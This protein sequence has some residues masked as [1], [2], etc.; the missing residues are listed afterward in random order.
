MKT[1]K[2]ISTATL[3]LIMIL[4]AV[5]AIPASAVVS[6]DRD[7]DFFTDY[8]PDGSI[9]AQG[10]SEVTTYG[11]EGSAFTQFTHVAGN[12]HVT[13][14]TVYVG[15]KFWHYPADTSQANYRTTTKNNTQ[16]GGSG[17]TASVSL[18]GG[19]ISSVIF[20]VESTH[21]LQYTCY[22]QTYPVQTVW[23]CAGEPAMK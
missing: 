12:N 21:T 7:S 6:Y 11:R 5:L 17:T 3:V 9:S 15:S 13:S 1:I 22:N 19:S 4:T 2:R 18:S 16:S 20:S 23:T 10:V 14:A 8:C